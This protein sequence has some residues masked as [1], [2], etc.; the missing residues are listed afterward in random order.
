[1]PSAH[2]DPTSVPDPRAWARATGH[3]AQ[4]DQCT[5][6][7]ARRPICRRNRLVA[8]TAMSRS[9][10]RAPMPTQMGRYVDWKGMTTPNQLSP[11]Q[12]VDEC[13][14]DMDAEETDGQ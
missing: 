1:M 4:V 9:R 5:T 8:I 3:S 2:P 7:Q 11:I 12:I 10:A 14:E 13:R 6:R